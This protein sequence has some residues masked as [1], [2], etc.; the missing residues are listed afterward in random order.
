[1]TFPL[2]YNMLFSKYAVALVQEQNSNIMRKCMNYKT[3]TDSPH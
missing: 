3:W 1:M 2:D